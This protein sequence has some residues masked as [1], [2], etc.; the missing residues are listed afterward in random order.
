MTCRAACDILR[1]A[2]QEGGKQGQIGERNNKPNL[3]ALRQGNQPC[4]IKSPDERNKI[5]ILL[6]LDAICDR[7]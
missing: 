6:R 3:V 2:Q 1:S 4:L 7:I 5:K